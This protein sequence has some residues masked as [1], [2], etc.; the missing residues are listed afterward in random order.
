[1]RCVDFG[2]VGEFGRQFV[3]GVDGVGGAD[4]DACA[5]IDAVVRIHIKVRNVGETSLVLLRM[6]AVH[7]AGLYAQFVFGAAFSNYVCHTFLAE[8]F[9]FQ[10]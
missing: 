6:D 4:R 3:Q 1:M 8:Q 7:R 5:A 9:S 10:V 2:E